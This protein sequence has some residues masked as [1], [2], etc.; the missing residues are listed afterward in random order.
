MS[1][2]ALFDSNL[3]LMG[4]M[5]LFLGGLG[6]ILPELRI[7]HVSGFLAVLI[8]LSVRTAMGC[9]M[10]KLPDDL[11]REV[12]DCSHPEKFVQ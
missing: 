8:T 11:K 10:Q 4:L 1:F 2:F 5:C 3:F 7:M 12:L 9:K 6:F